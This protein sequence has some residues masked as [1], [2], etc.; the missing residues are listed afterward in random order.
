MSSDTT[1]GIDMC[2]YF[3]KN[4]HIRSTLI[5]PLFKNEELFKKYWNFDSADEIKK[6]WIIQTYKIL[7]NHNY[8]MTNLEVNL[9][10]YRMFRK[11]TENVVVKYYGNHVN[12]KGLICSTCGKMF[13][14]DDAQL[15]DHHKQYCYPVTKHSFTSYEN[16]IPLKIPRFPRNVEHH[17][18]ICVSI[19]HSVDEYSSYLDALSCFKRKNIDTRF[20]FNNLDLNS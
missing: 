5:Y 12:Y 11:Y 16:K 19:I 3:N 9:H 13:D 18:I 1:L 15:H 10:L 2:H 6:E 7:T 8:S 17:P 14:A 4:N 20:F